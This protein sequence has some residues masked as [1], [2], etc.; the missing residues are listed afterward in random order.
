M[1]LSNPKKLNISALDFTG[2]SSIQF[3]NSLL[4]LIHR[5]PLTK[6]VRLVGVTYHLLCSAGVTYRTL[7]HT[8]GH[9]VLPTQ[10]FP[11]EAEDIPKGGKCFNHVPQPT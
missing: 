1:K 9:Q 6:L 3:F 7:C 8:I 2:C 5:R 11:R 10:P 4:S